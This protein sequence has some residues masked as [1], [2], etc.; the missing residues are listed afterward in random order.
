MG[1]WWKSSAI[2]N[3]GTGWRR[4][5]S[6][7][8]QSFYPRGKSPWYRLHR[9]LCWP[10]S[11]SGR[12]G[13]KKKSLIPAGSQTPVRSPS[14]R[15]LSY[16]GSYSIRERIYLL[17]SHIRSAYEKSAVIVKK[18]RSRDFERLTRFQAP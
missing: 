14:L 11:R 8:L 13:V 16:P 5:V 18:Y 7:M 9:R 6:F 4:V 17:L 15:Q 10:Q 1:K 2:L 12:C 3:L